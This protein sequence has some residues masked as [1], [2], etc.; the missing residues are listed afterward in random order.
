M[1]SQM[2]NNCRSF[3][4][5]S[6]RNVVSSNRHL[7]PQAFRNG[8]NTYPGPT[9]IGKFVVVSLLRCTIDIWS[10]QNGGADLGEGE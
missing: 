2:F 4:C 1:H 7:K 9:V 10:Q 8:D 5:F 3:L 6:N